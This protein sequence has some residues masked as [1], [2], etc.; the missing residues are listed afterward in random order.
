MTRIHAAFIAFAG[1]LPL[2]FLACSDMGDPVG[3]QRPPGVSLQFD[4]QP[5]F[6]SRCAIAGCHVQPSPQAGMNLS[7]G[8]SYSNTVNQ[9]AIVF[10]P[11]T[12]VIPGDPDNSV[13]YQLVSTGV[14]P[15][16]GGP[17]TSEQIETIREWIADGAE[18]N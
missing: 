7:A 6:S 2:L 16:Q 4:V 17:L 1:I 15:L 9:P 14:M 10:G 12:R 18:N 8:V 3:A 5:I 11:G 13:L